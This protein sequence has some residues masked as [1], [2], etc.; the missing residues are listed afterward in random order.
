MHWLNKQYSTNG[1][2]ENH[3]Q[4]LELA[5]IGDM[6]AILKYLR[7]NDVQK[8]LQAVD[9]KNKR[10]ALHIAA[11]NGHLNLVEFL[12]HKLAPVDARDKLLKTPLHYACES[13][14]AH[15]IEKLI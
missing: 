4:F 11:K 9:K 6:D 8:A 13:G 12:I 2:G 1:Q 14:N 5:T 3:D 10:T 7:K 15:V